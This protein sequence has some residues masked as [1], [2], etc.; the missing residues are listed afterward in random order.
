MKRKAL[1]VFMSILLTA[2][3]SLAV[4]ADSYT[5]KSG[6]AVEY[7]GTDLSA[8]FKTGEL[9][10]AVN[11][12]LPGDSITLT[13]SLKN[14]GDKDTDWWMSNTVVNSFEDSSSKAAGG[15]YEY[16]L[17]YTGPSGTDTT[18]YSSN[19]V[20]G[21]D[22]TY[23]EGLHEATDALENFFFLETLS[24]GQ[25][26]KITLTIALDG[27]TQG[28]SYQK[29]LADLEMSF[30]VEERAETPT[31][32]YLIVRTGDMTNMMPYYTLA[33]V[34]GIGLLAVAT[35]YAFGTRRRSKAGR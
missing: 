15:A 25:Q 9:A 7:T 17:T 11:E 6:W 27:E 8:N 5:G 23:G 20:G 4:F 3:L 24:K 35:V 18:L 14:S 28:N 21:D 2:T 19:A 10:E 26:A 32:N 22:T 34:S 16:E 12:I 31:T 13:V 1:L 33:I 30:A 29:T